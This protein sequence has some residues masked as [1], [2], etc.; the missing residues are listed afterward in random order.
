[1]PA[2]ESTSSVLSVELYEGTKR[3]PKVGTPLWPKGIDLQGEAEGCCC[4]FGLQTDTT[5]YFE[6]YTPCGIKARVCNC[7]YCIAKWLARTEV[8]G[9]FVIWIHM[10]EVHSNKAQYSCVHLQAWTSW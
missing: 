2:F 5:I 1:M 9:N 3:A 10:L 8:L 6:L 7:M 4:R